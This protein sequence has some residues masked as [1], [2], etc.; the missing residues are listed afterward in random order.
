MRKGLCAVIKHSSSDGETASRKKTWFL[1]K[2]KEK[3]G[4]KKETGRFLPKRGKKRKG[5]VIATMCAVAALAVF[6]LPKLLRGQQNTALLD[7]NDT[8]VLSYTDIQSSIS[9]T[10]TVASASSTMV[11]STAS[12]TVKAVYAEVGDFVEAGALLAELDDQSIQDQIQSQQISMEQSAASGAQQVQTAQ[13]NYDNYKTGLEQGLNST[14]NS[15]QNQVQTAYE[16][17]VKA[18]NTYER[19]RA[20]L[21]AGENTT[22]LNAESAL[23]TAE[24]NL[25]AAR[26]S[27]DAA[28][29]RCLEAQ[30]ALDDVQGE[31]SAAREDLSA[32]RTALETAQSELEAM[33]QEKASLEQL[34]SPSTEALIRLNELNASIAAQETDISAIQANIPTLESTVSE[35]GGAYEQADSQYQQAYSAAS[36][37]EAALDNAEDSYALQKATYNASLTSVD[38]SLA[39]YRDSMDSAWNSYQNAQTSLASTQKTVQEQLQSYQNSL[40]SAKINSSTASAQE[41]LRQLRADLDGTQITAPCSGTVTAVYAKVGSSGSGLLFVIEDVDDLVVDTSVKGYDVGTVQA[42]MRVVIRSDATGSKEM[43]GT[44]TRIAPT[45]TKNSQGLTDTSSDAVF[46]AEVRVDGEAAGLRIG[47]EAQLDYIVGEE[48]HVLAVPYDAVYTNEEGVRCVLAAAEQENGRFLLEEL[49]VSTG[50]DDDL[51]IAVSGANIRE[52]LRII[53]EPETYR[54]LLGQTVTAGTAISAAPGGVF[55][56]A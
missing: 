2:R 56:G 52:G 10:G 37:A 39:D 42:G 28:Q 23:R 18:K 34:P 26:E 22:L 12:Y 6:A 3:T 4:G 33:M 15:A 38:N 31:L 24:K 43:D 21:D 9:A 55:G 32:S 19:Y 11:Y 47:M 29:E 49:E 16:S 50:I 14:L 35:L 45:S 48:R 27:Y 5:I 30:I 54:H 53:N 7:L 25:D 17:Y 36:S 44:V 41:S 51:D 46:A 8:T 40:S 20:G 13:D 1:W